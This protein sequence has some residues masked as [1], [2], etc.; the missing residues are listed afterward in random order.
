MTETVDAK[1]NRFDPTAALKLLDGVT[2][3]VFESSVSAPAAPEE[4]QPAV[5]GGEEPK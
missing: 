1:K 3:L 5:V 2:K 4:P